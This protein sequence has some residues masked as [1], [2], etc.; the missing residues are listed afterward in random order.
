MNN[1]LKIF[2]IFNLV[3]ST[4]SSVNNYSI[5]LPEVELTMKQ[6]SSEVVKRDEPITLLGG[7][8]IQGV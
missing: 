8:T 5:P 4:A 7:T 6:N 2:L 1:L 3:S